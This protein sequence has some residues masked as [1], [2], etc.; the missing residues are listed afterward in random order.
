MPRT[1]RGTSIAG[2]SR[3]LPIFAR[4]ERPSA[5]SLRTVG[6]QPGRLAHGPEEKQEF[7]GRTPGVLVVMTSHPFRWKPLVG[8]RCPAAAHIGIVK[9]RQAACESAFGTRGQKLADELFNDA[10][11]SKNP[12]RLRVPLTLGLALPCPSGFANLNAFALSPGALRLRLRSVGVFAPA[13]IPHARQ[14]KDLGRAAV[15]RSHEKR[16]VRGPEMDD[17]VHAAPRESVDRC[18][19]PQCQRAKVNKWS[20]GRSFEFTLTG[21]TAPHCKFSLSPENPRA[22]ILISQAPGGRFVTPGDKGT[23]A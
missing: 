7:A 11:F 16:T 3:A 1:S 2:L 18:D 13:L 22:I 14:Q 9:Q 19:R 23:V 4:C 17:I 15:A 12:L 10:P 21:I 20:K 6:D 8:E 5:A